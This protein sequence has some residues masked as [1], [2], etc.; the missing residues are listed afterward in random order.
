F[1]SNCQ[2]RRAGSRVSGLFLWLSPI[3]SL[4]QQVNRRL[5]NRLPPLRVS[6][7]LASCAYELGELGPF[8]SSFLPYSFLPLPLRGEYL[9]SPGPR[10]GSRTLVRLFLGRRLR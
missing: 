7:R 1:P 5:R 4:K 10:V 2:K 8:R 9:P 3:W 6:D